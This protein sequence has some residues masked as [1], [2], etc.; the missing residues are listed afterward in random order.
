MTAGYAELHAATNFS[1]LRGAS[2]PEELFAVA[3]VLGLP[4]LGVTDRN[5]LAGIVRAWEAARATKLRL[6][7]GC[8][9]DLDD[10][11]AVLAYP[12]D[13]PAYSR[14]CQL[15]TL[16]KKGA[17]KEGWSLG[18][19][20]LTHH[21]EGLLTVLLPGEVDDAL[22]GRLARL[23]RDFGRRAYAAL[24]LHRRPG[25][26]VRLRRIADLAAAA[27]VPTVATGDVPTTR[28]ADASCRT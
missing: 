11:A 23:R 21:G 9:L 2:H 5:S 6:V 7:V 12:T 26:V 24:T 15:L 13:R 1:F 16:G 17:R 14:L 10:G 18:W 25:D 3:A 4:A 8:R 20:D 27:G 22:A 19:D 28:P